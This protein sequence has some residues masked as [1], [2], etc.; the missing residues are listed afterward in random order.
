MYTGF[1]ILLCIIVLRRDMHSIE[2]DKMWSKDNILPEV[3]NDCIDREQLNMVGM[4][5]FSYET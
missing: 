2:F 5:S 4:S 3:Q 1:R